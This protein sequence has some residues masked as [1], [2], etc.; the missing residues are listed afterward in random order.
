MIIQL[1][2]GAFVG[3]LVFLK[4]Y[5]YRFKNFLSGKSREESE[6]SENSTNE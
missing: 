3:G 5:W 6:S 1:V 4:F 2:V